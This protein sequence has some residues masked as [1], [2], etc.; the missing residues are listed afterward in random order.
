MMRGGEKGGGECSAVLQILEE[1]ET[2][3]QMQEWTESSAVVSG[4]KVLY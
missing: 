2:A 4:C 3:S 1:P